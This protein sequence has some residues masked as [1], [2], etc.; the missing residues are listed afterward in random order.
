MVLPQVKALEAAAAARAAEE[1]KQAERAKL[2]AAK[3]AGK[4]GQ[5]QT[6]ALTTNMNVADAAAPH[7]PRPAGADR[8]PEVADSVAATPAGAAA[9]SKVAAIEQILSD[10]VGSGGAV[11]VPVAVKVTEELKKPLDKDAAKRKAEK[12]ADAAK[13]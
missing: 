11:R 6:A 7:K 12:D 1:A 4:H 2:K 3:T 8:L 13:R 5:P 10:K 9:V